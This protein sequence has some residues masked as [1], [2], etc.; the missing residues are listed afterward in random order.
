MKKPINNLSKFPKLFES[1]YAFAETNCVILIDINGFILQVNRAFTTSFGYNEKDI[2]GKHARILFTAEDQKINRPEVEFKQVLENGS[3]QDQNY[4][5]HKKGNPVWT[6]GESIL[7][8]NENNEKCICKMIQNIHTQKLQEQFL[9]N[10]NEFVE[11]ILKSMEDALLVIDMNFQIQKVNKAFFKVFDM[12]DEPVE[13]KSL[14]DL[15]CAFWGDEKVQKKLGDLFVE[16]NFSLQDE[17]EWNIPGGYIRTLRITSKLMEQNVETE[18]RILLIINDITAQ[19]Q[20]DQNR[21]DLIAFVSH[22]LRNPLANLALVIDLLKDSFQEN[23]RAF[24]EE[25]V[26]SANINIRRLNKMVSELTEATKA[27]GGQLEIDKSN[28]S[29]QDVVDEA[30]ESV[31]SLYPG[32]HICQ[33]NKTDLIVNADRHKLMQVINNYLTNA[34]KYS[35]HNKEIDIGL[36]VENNNLQLSVTDKGNGIPADQLPHVF[37]RYYR[38]ASTRKIEGLGLG[39]Y[40]SKEIITAHSGRVWADSREGKGSSFY[41]VIPMNNIEED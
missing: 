18:K 8:E 32:Y 27:M 41:F 36:C 20:T 23:N 15:N 24:T 34:I 19:K 39:L 40:L 14:K 11:N 17:F 37:N 7:V 26:K 22:E 35:P 28:F 13:Q 5:M 30:V 6:T 33:R 16:N 12:T 29:F 21:E 3:A 31:K 2:V 25:Y 10:S 4:L 38:G 1:L 9:G